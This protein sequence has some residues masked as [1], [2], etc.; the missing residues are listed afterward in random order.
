V[1]WQGDEFAPMRPTVLKRRY[2]TRQEALTGLQD[3]ALTINLSG[4]PLTSPSG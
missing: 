1:V 2:R 3:L 4:P